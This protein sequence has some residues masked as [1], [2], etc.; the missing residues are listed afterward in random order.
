MIE[1]SYDDRIY[2]LAHIFTVFVIIAV[3]LSSFMSAGSVGRNRRISGNHNTIA[4]DNIRVNGNNNTIYS[5]NS[6]ING[7]HNNI[8][9]DNNTVSGN[10]NTVH[11]NN[12]TIS[13]NHN[14][15]TPNANNRVSGN[16]NREISDDEVI[17]EPDLFGHEATTIPPI[18]EFT[19]EI[20]E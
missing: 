16:N 11:G 8:Y 12:N 5:S 3:L 10:N 17:N 6:R 20:F 1:K 2:I 18:D 9:G 19:E 14:R 13:G 7:N 4:E 15:F